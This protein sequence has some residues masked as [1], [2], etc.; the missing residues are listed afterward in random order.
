MFNNSAAQPTRL[1]ELAKAANLD[2]NL[3]AEAIMVHLAR[4]S[5]DAE[6]KEANNLVDG[7]ESI[8][9]E[10]ADEEEDHFSATVYGSRYAAE[11][12]PRNEMPEREMPKEVYVL[13][14]ARDDVGAN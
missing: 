5:T 3:L 4:V 12:L 7:L 10:Q 11:D 13:L 6:V 9:F 8:R 1:E 2:T 14:Q